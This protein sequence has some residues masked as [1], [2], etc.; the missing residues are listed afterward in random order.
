MAGEWIKVRTNLWDDPRVCA[1]CDLTGA[2]EAFVIGGLYW[3]WSKAATGA[4]V[5]L[6]G[7]DNQVGISGFGNALIAS[8]WLH[9]CADGLLVARLAP[10]GLE[11][12]QIRD[13]HLRP[14]THEW[15]VIRARI[16]QRD[17]YTCQYCGAS[18]CRLECDHV[19]PVARGGAH[20]DDNL[21]T[22]CFP[23]N[24]SKRDKLLTEWRIKK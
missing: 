16:F 6:A 19:I 3:L 17:N 15:A 14:P 9:A 22:A 20:A 1:M 18:A 10:D 23:C 5:T 7:I 4:D 2:S 8:R 21:A 24:R 13:E 12:F 11:I